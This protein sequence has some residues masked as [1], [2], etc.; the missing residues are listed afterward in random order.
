MERRR[1]ER[2]R[3]VANAEIKANE[4]ISLGETKTVRKRV[5]LLLK[6]FGDLLIKA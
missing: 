2:S 6:T 3:R 5:A 4:P 1:K